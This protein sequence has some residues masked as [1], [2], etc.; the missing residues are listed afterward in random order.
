MWT[1]VL[2]E[3]L[4]L[5]SD[6]ILNEWMFIIIL[7]CTPRSLHSCLSSLLT[8]VVYSILTSAMRAGCATYRVVL[9][10]IIT[11]SSVNSSSPPTASSSTTPG[12]HWLLQGVCLCHAFLTLLCNIVLMAQ[13]WS[14]TTETCSY[15]KVKNSS[16]VG[17][18]V[19]DL[20]LNDTQTKRDV[21]H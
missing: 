10:F 16:C 13:W 15:T 14:K 19:I 6:R 20:F 5:S 9:N 8:N 11:I 12:G 3:A 2:E 4:D 21:L 7:H 18:T 1:I 17:P